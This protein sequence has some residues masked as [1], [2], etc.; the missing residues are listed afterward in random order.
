MLAID[1]KTLSPNQQ[2]S[3]NIH[4]IKQKHSFA[5]I[6]L[7]MKL[8]LSLSQY[9]KGLFAKNKRGYKLTAKNK[10]FWSLL[11]LVLSVVS[12]RRK[13]LKTTYTWER[14]VH[15]NLESCNIR[16]INCK[17]INLISSTSFI[18]YHQ[19]FFHMFI[20]SFIIFVICFIYKCT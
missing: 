18:Y 19:L 7:L 4:V 9:L 6:V 14:S 2:G 10:H 17:L 12:L 16:R 3:F 5:D 20:Y 15:T 13:F 11:I 1:K 8:F